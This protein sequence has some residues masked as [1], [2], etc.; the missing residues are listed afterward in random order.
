[1]HTLPSLLNMFFILP[2]LQRVRVAH[3]GGGQSHQ[4]PQGGGL[5][6][7]MARGQQVRALFLWLKWGCG[8]RVP[9]CSGSKEELEQ[10]Q[11]AL[12]CLNG[13]APCSCLH[14]MHS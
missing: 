13:Q 9:M 14:S 11:L 5:P 7:W 1:M 6:A 10:Q 4:R 8:R 2:S 12:Q 3:Q